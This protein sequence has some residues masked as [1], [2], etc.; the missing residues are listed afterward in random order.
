MTYPH[1]SDERQVETPD[2]PSV[3]LA[4]L[5][6]RLL[7]GFRATIGARTIAQT[8]WRRSKAQTL[9]KLLALAP[10]HRL[11]REQLLETLWPD[12]GP[13]AAL[14]ALH[15]ALHAARRA[16]DAAPA[17]AAAYLHLEGEWL[18]LC[19]E[20][21]L[22][23]DVQAFREAVAGARQ[24]RDPERYR[25]ALE[26]YTGELLPED[27]YAD[28]SRD[29]RE[30]LRELRLA[31]LC[32]LARLHEERGELRAAVD[33]LQQV[34]GLEPTHEEAQRDL[35]RLF[36]LTGQRSRA[37]QQ[38]EQ[39][40]TALA[41]DLDAE[42]DPSSQ[43]LYEAIKHGHFPPPAPKAPVPDR[44]AP[45]RRHNL[46]ALSSALVGREQE[47]AQLKQM[48][49]EHR[50]VTLGGAG[51]SGKT[52]LALALASEVVDTYADGVW[53]VELASLADP[54]LVPYALAQSLG[55]REAG[56]G[57]LHSMLLD[58]LRHRETLLV[59]D[60][61]EHLVGACAELAAML[62]AECPR[63]SIV[64]TSREA[65]RVAGEAVYSVPTL[66]VPERGRPLSPAAL[67]AYPA[68]R[69]FVD[70][71]RSHRGDFALTPSNREAV[72]EICRRLD[73]IPLAIELAAARV[74]VMTAEQI[75]ARLHD[76]TRLLTGGN[77]TASPR[78]R[79]LAGALAWSYDLLTPAEQALF[80]WLSV[81]A[82]GWTLEAAEALGTDR[83]V[84]AED[85]LDLIERLVEQSLA[86]AEAG[87]DGA[88]RY[89]MLE[90]VRQYAEQRLVA[91]GEAE[92]IRDRH[93]ALFLAL[94]ERAETEFGGP[95]HAWWLARLEVEHNNIRAAVAWAVEHG[96]GEIAARIGWSLYIFWW[97]RGHFGEIRRRMEQVLASEAKLP[98]LSRTKACFVAGGMA[99]AQGDLERGI[100]LCDESIRLLRAAGDRRALA[101]VLLVA[102][103]PHARRGDLA[104]AIMLLE[105]SVELFRALGAT[106]YLASTLT[107][108]ARIVMLQ[109]E[110]N[111]ANRLADEG[112]TLGRAAGDNSIVAMGLYTQAVPALQSGD[113]DGAAALLIEGLRAAA[114]FGS[115]I[116]DCIQGLGLVALARHDLPRAVR[117]WAAVAA[118]REAAGAPAQSVEHALY[119]PHLASA[120]AQIG[121]APKWERG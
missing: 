21:A 119:A 85:V 61:C 75:V 56:S 99:A 120:R 3:Q 32:E 28:W 107:R 110:P 98:D 4:A 46:P 52:S 97:T 111:R 93:A 30:E 31:L 27:R 49:I 76:A 15:Q 121:D 54:L 26:L 57:D 1:R 106:W 103:Y 91:A 50:L 79:T 23:T 33:V 2:A 96:A 74:R 95:R 7:G 80:R 69:L 115:I 34:V 105:E 58:Y 92:L 112:I 102:S 22:R 53:L 60:N 71:A 88:M 39:L 35:M 36:A 12:S 78:Q 83:D 82:G 38:Y 87:T 20:H 117:L 17:E 37:L 81:F 24:A 100:T 65:L 45:L 16:L 29:R 6:I 63:V 70:R 5:R 101:L 62:L 67:E 66:A 94:A 8:E 51:G 44:V 11:H 47:R 90:P 116:V 55:L 41:N 84:H 72:A 19:P 77:R 114:A 25:R 42:P 10:Q 86:L 40:R 118:L 14:N 59:L 73:G 113:Y 13:A 89:R 64:A 18:T 108:L 68:V 104:T 9:V 48:L 109:G 43:E